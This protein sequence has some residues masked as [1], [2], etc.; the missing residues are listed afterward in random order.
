MKVEAVTANPEI[1]ITLTLEEAVGL[2][3]LLRSGTSLGL[4]DTLKIGGLQHLLRDAIDPHVSKLTYGYFE[5]RLYPSD[6][7]V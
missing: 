7:I 3:T 4:D 5:K 1:V 2:N 6:M